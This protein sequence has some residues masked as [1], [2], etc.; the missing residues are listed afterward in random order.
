MS[1]L[2][3]VNQPAL[4]ERCCTLVGGES[5]QRQFRSC[6]NPSA[7]SLGLELLTVTKPSFIRTPQVPQRRSPGGAESGPARRGRAPG[8]DGRGQGVFR[9]RLFRGKPAI[10]RGTPEHGRRIRC[11]LEAAL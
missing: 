4:W 6:M 11:V 1:A 2:A 5:C 10:V 7:P 9:C 3:E 8:P